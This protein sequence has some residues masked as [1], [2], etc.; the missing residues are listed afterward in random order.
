MSQTEAKVLQL[1][2]EVELLRSAVFGLVGRDEEGDYRPA[3]VKKIWRGLGERPFFEFKNVDSFL[4]HLRSKK[5][6]A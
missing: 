1:E 2:K 6:Q 4:S 5:P 3:F